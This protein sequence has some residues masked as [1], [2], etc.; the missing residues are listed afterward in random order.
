[1]SENDSVFDFPC[2]FPIKA[3][4]RASADFEP[5]VRSLVL[6]HAELHPGEQVTVAS[7]GE[8]N[9]LSVTVVI[10]AQSRDQLDRIYQDL[11]D[12]AQILMAL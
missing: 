4:G 3:M 10:T 9:F 6:N 11:S 12:C 1:M 8:G 7:S 2:K 5:L